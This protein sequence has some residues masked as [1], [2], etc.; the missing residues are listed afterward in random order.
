MCKMLAAQTPMNNCKMNFVQFHTHCGISGLQQA[1][2]SS[3]LSFRVGPEVKLT[4]T[5]FSVAEPAQP[6]RMSY[7]E[8]VK[9]ASPACKV[10]FNIYAELAALLVT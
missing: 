3:N 9:G 8:T 2:P 6:G 7:A 1:S 4:F 10:E 5:L